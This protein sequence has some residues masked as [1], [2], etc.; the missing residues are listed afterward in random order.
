MTVGGD[1]VSRFALEHST[2]PEWLRSM[3][4]D[5]FDALSVI[6]LAQLAIPMVLRMIRSGL[7]AVKKP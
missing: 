7:R 5:V 2:V 3:I 6:A 4:Y 1:A